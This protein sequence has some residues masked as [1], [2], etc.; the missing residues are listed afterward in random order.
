MKSLRFCFFLLFILS[1][2]KEQELPTV[3]TGDISSI[4]QTSAFCKGYLFSQGS[5]EVISK[6]ICW[7]T[8]GEPT[9]HDDTITVDSSTTFTIKLTDLALNTKYYVRAFAI[10]CVGTA[11][12]ETKSFSTDPPYIPEVRTYYGPLS[13]ITTTSITYGGVVISD[14]AAEITDR[15]LC[16]GTSENPTLSDNFISAGSGSDPFSVSINGLEPN[17]DYFVRAYATNIAGTGFGYYEL[18]TTKFEADPDLPVDPDYPT[19]IY[20]LDNNTLLQ[21]RTAYAER[22]KYLRTTLD[23]YGFCDLDGLIDAESPPFIGEISQDQAIDTVK[24]FISNNPS[25]TGINNP[26]EINFRRI[27]KSTN[28]DGSITWVF[29]ISDQILDNSPVLTTELLIHVLNGEVT[30]CLGNWYPEIYFP[31]NLN[32]D[33]EAAKSILLGRLLEYYNASGQYNFKTISFYDL[34]QATINLSVLHISNNDTIELHVAWQ[35]HLDNIWYI[36]YVDVMTGEILRKKITID[37]D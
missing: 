21:K 28:G 13:N 11:Y 26:D 16:W 5:C 17:T 7:N 37:I 8:T 9:V 35:I 6:G 31:V 14:G 15:G 20:K 32:I 1:G 23:E 29:R 18:C 25:E 34:N 19:K 3:T 30:W 36:L 27:T 33:Q 22:N 12:G 10:N 2:C 4:T 24:S